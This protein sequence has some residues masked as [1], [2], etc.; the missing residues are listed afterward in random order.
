MDDEPAL[1]STT[2]TIIIIIIIIILI[3]IM[4]V[5]PLG[6]W[7]VYKSSPAFSAAGDKPEITAVVLPTFIQCS[8]SP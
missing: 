1:V 2:T 3:V 6:T 7:V 5:V 4:S 8:S